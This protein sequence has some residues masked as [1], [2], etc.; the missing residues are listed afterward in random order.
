MNGKL[1]TVATIGLICAF[2]FLA[3]G[4]A[5]SGS[6]LASA[7]Y[8]WDGAQF[9]CGSQGS[10][11]QQVVLPFNSNGSLAIDIPASVRYQPGGK[12]EAV[13]SG[14]PALLDHVRLEGGRLSLDC[15]PGWSMSRFDVSLS[16]A[17]VTDWKVHGSGDLSLSQLDQADLRLTIFGSGSVTATGSVKTVDLD[18]AG[19]GAAR[20]KDLA[21][22]SV[23]LRIRGSGDA[24]V[25]AA[26]DADISISGSGNV[27]LYGH[28]IVRRSEIRGSGRLVQVP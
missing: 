17:P 19:S 22:Q 1:A 2:V 28:P 4:A 20:L 23:K 24:Q 15:H 13:I 3:L 18:V 7:R 16:G 8:W 25:S 26:A 6:D 21:T 9:G 12:A 11:K 10:G 5:L 14:N 27:E